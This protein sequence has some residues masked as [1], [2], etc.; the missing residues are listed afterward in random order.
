ME[1]KIT[2]STWLARVISR[3]TNPC[4]LS[5]AVLFS[6]AFTEST[7]VRALVNWEMTLLLFL[8]ILP[9]TYTYMRS[10]RNRSRTRPRVNPIIFL[11]QHP[12]DIL[13]LGFLSGLPCMAILV[14][15]EAPLLLLETLIA[16]LASSIIVAS[17]NIFYRVSYHLAGL[18]ISVVMS[19]ITW[20]SIFLITLAAIPLISWAKYQLH[21]HTPT[22]LAIGIVIS[23]AVTG[24]ILYV[25]SS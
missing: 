22:Q 16:L 23:L 4:I 21:E 13:I 3:V 10:S 19:I 2:R 11:K 1:S 12:R 25:C 14:F 7:N 15:L 5:V 24:I 8:V 20:G 9:I 17:L 6:I 18:T